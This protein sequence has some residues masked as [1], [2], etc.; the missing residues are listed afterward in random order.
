M[1]AEKWKPQGLAEFNKGLTQLQVAF[2][3]GDCDEAD[4]EGGDDKYDEVADEPDDEDADDEDDELADEAG[5]EDGEAA[6]IDDAYNDQAEEQ[7]FPPLRS[8]THLVDLCD[9]ILPPRSIFG[10]EPIVPFSSS[11][12]PFSSSIN[13]SSFSSTSLPSPSSPAPSFLPS[14][15][16]TERPT[17]RTFGSPC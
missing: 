3:D 1:T 16:V 15:W 12:S 8:L 7:T 6:D 10:C 2:H 11:F 17:T 9:D 13:V 5:D 4:D 14:S